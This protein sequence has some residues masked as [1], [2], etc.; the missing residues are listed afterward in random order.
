[1]LP[2]LSRSRETWTFIRMSDAKDSKEDRRRTPRRR[3][4]KRGKAILH[5]HTTLF[6]CTIRDQSAGGARLII[7]A[8]SLPREFMLFNVSDN[9]TRDVRVVWRHGNEV[10]VEYLAERADKAVTKG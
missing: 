9:E 10:G 4:L 7:H 6:D 3:V 8:M 5:N 2:V 1:L